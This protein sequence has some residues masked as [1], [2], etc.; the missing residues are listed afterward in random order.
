MSRIETYGFREMLAGAG[1][2]GVEIQ[3]I[4]VRTPDDYP[5]A[6]ATLAASRADALH[7]FGNPVSFK[8]PQL[9]ADFALRNMLP[10]IYDEKLFV[11]AGGLLSYGPSFIDLFQRAASY[12]DKILKGAKPGD[13]PIQ[14]PTK[15]EFVINSKTAKAL[16]LTVPRSLLVLADEVIQ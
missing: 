15:F 5:A 11:E 10:S 12:V 9:I 7:A 16:G 2:V 4:E 14:Q 1:V 8:H 13:L 6:F 3:S